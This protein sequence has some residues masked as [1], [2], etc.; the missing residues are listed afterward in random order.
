IVGPGWIQDGNAVGN[1]DKIWITNTTTRKPQIRISKQGSVATLYVD[2]HE[3]F[4]LTGASTNSNYVHF[5]DMGG[6]ADGG[7]VNYEYIAWAHEAKGDENMTWW[8]PERWVY[9]LDFSTEATT[10]QL[11][12]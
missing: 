8:E 4:Q 7:K 6:G 12:G 5:G 9:G 3:A 11:G 10:P 1:P 2:G